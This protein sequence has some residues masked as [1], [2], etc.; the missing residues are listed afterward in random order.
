MV[1]GWHYNTRLLLARSFSPSC[2]EK[3]I[4]IDRQ[5]PLVWFQ[6]IVASLCSTSK[7]Y[8]DADRLLR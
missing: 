5:D 2:Y 3:S 1:A 6:V 8:E 4:D 7:K